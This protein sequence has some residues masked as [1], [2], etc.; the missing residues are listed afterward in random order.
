MSDFSKDCVVKQQDLS[1]VKIPQ[2]KDSP[3]KPAQ[4]P[5]RRLFS[6]LLLAV[7]VACAGAM[8]AGGK[9]PRWINPCHLPGHPFDPNTDMTEAPP[10]RLSE[11]YE[12]VK[13]RARVAKEHAEHLRQYFKDDFKDFVDG[14]ALYRQKWLPSI[15]PATEDEFRNV[16]GREA[17]LKSFEFLQFFAVG[18]EQILLDQ[19]IH[20]GQF[21]RPFAELEDNLTQVLCELQL[22]LFTLRVPP[23]PDVL[24]DVMSQD[25]RDLSG[26]SYRNLRDYLI[27]RDY[28]YAM[29]Y[30]SALFAYLERTLDARAK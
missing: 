1:D 29:H 5:P 23:S 4:R 28:V 18:I 19:T 20:D 2:L 8:P 9:K 12:G 30:V 27:L 14:T 24:R 25:Y 7:A 21:L 11:L 17:F 16:E 26:R 22:G 15:P 13:E 10:L 6:A 3:A